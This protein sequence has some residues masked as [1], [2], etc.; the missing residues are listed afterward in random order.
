MRERWLIA[1]NGKTESIYITAL[2]QF[3][4]SSAVEVQHFPKDPLSQVSDA[5][6]FA[7]RQPTKFA[8]VYIVFDSDDFDL[9]PAFEKLK[10][11]NERSAHAA[12]KAGCVWTAIV[13]NPCF[14]LWYLL[15][16]H[17]TNAAFCGKTPCEDLQRHFAN[18]FQ[19]YK[20]VDQRAAKLLVEQKLNVAC[21]NAKKLDGDSSTSKTDLW[22]LVRDLREKSESKE[23]FY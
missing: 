1:V 7:K 2:R 19:N 18:D 17:Y 10:A 12:K 4:R 3:F 22:K 20:K 5:E 8:R 23:F 11:L 16:F 13:S 9:N 15:H 21:E 14:E 6:R